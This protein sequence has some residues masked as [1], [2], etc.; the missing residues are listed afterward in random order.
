MKLQDYVSLKSLSEKF[1]KDVGLYFYVLPYYSRFAFWRDY[2][3]RYRKY[4][5]RGTTCNICNNKYE[6]FV[7]YM[8]APEDKDALVRHQV[9]AGYNQNSFC[10][11]CMSTDRDRLVISML[12]SQTDL[13]EKRILHLAP[14]RVIY[15]FIKEKFKANSITADFDPERYLYIDRKIKFADLCN[16]PFESVFF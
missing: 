15:R 7:P 10:P 14:E 8:P 12:N 9:I 13:K 3:R 5:G 6:Q 2:G 16:L 11:S 4:K 1:L